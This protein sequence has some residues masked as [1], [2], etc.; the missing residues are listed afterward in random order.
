[1]PSCELVLV[2]GLLVVSRPHGR[3]CQ[4][5]VWLAVVQPEIVTTY[6]DRYH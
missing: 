6:H 1:M 5:S 4:R 2:S 3:D